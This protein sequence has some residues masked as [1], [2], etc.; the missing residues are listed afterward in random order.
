MSWCQNP[1]L[2][3]GS[4]YVPRILGKVLEIHIFRL[5]LWL[6]LGFENVWLQNYFLNL[7]QFLSHH[8]SLQNFPTVTE[9]GLKSYMVIVPE[10][11]EDT[12]QHFPSGTIHRFLN[13][14]DIMRNDHQ[15]FFIS[16][17][18]ILRN[19]IAS[20]KNIKTRESRIFF[21]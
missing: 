12:M 9:N 19:K 14:S 4:P 7:K 20:A 3:H 18:I 13:L 11:L 8:R 10:D 17:F 2:F 6:I 1:F 15:I 21:W 16:H 5:I